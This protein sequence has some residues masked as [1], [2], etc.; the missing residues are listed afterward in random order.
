M[1][2]RFYTVI[3]LFWVVFPVNNAQ[4][5]RRRRR[6]EGTDVLSKARWVVQ[7]SNEQQNSF[8]KDFTFQWIDTLFWK[9]GNFV[10]KFQ[11]FILL[12]ILFHSRKH[13]HNYH[14]LRGTYQF[15]NTLVPP[16]PTPSQTSANFVF[17]SENGFWLWAR[18]EI[19]ISGSGPRDYF[20]G[21]FSFTKLDTKTLSAIPDV[22]IPVVNSM[23]Y[24]YTP[25]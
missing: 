18:S 4:L 12:S 14:P 13:T 1:V 3:F 23:Y 6:A 17:S 7:A 15:E 10:A 25:L 19:R 2:Q 24:W 20:S 5:G 11:G 9:W 8:L 22:H 16:P 21:V